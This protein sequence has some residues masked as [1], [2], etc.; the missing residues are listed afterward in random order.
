MG[1]AKPVEWVLSSCQGKEYNLSHKLKGQPKTTSMKTTIHHATAEPFPVSSA[2][3]PSLNYTVKDRSSVWIVVVIIAMLFGGAAYLL[4]QEPAAQG[5]GPRYAVTDLRS[6]GGTNSGGN[7]INDQTWVAGYSTLSGDLSRHAALWRNGRILDLGTLGGPNSSVAWPVKNTRGFLAGISQTNKVQPLGEYWS[8]LAF[9]SGPDAVK[10]VCLGFVWKQGQM[11]ALSTLG[12]D[13]G[14]ATG[15]NNNG[16]VAGWAENACRDSTCVPPQVLQFR[17]VVWNIENNYKIHELP[18]AFGDTSGAATALNDFNQ[19]VGISGIC[20][21]AVGRHTAKHA[22]LWHNGKVTDLGNLGAQW[23]NTPTAINQQ[24]DVTGFAGDPAYPEGD[25][26]HAF[27]WTKER[28]MRPLGAL[29]GHVHSEA[30]GINERRQIVGI[31]CDAS[32]ADCRAFLWDNGVMRDLNDLK[33]AGYAGKL[34]RG[35]DINNR[36]EITGRAVDASGTVRTSFLALPI[37]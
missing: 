11:T 2:K 22:V 7:S 13:N 34:E 36:G 21:Q 12:G 27:I 26:L 37:H 1:W 23:W 32:G 10:Y 4:A 9:F 8:Q 35:K 25:I 20:D 28:G 17:P 29:P 15:V 16:L 30:Y 6:L 5:Q 3:A 14:F 31:S 18:L 19:V 33:Q 24:G